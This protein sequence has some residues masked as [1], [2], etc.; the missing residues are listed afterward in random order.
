VNVHTPG[1]VSDNFNLTVQPTAPAVFLSGVAG[2]QVNIPTVIRSQNNMLVTD[3]NPIQHGD[4]LVIYLTGCGQTT[5][6]VGDGLPAPGSPF[7]LTL[8]P[9][10]VL[11]G[12]TSLPTMYA[13]LAPGQVGVCQINATVPRSVPTGLGLP[14]TITQ[15]AGTQTLSLRVIE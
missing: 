4:T 11:L 1:G 8:T 6:I 15:G 12:G 5:P 10:T 7:A 2:P 3:S 14:L 9:P 13:G